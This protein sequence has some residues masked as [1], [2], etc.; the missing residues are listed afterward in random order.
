MVSNGEARDGNGEVRDGSG[1]EVDDFC[2]VRDF[3]GEVMDDFCEVRCM[4]CGRLLFRTKKIDSPI[5]I[6]CTRCNEKL[7]LLQVPVDKAAT[8]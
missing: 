5:E 7:L 6:V 2:E 4:K 3:N 1:E 8:I